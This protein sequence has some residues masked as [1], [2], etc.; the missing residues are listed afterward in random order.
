MR[1]YLRQLKLIKGNLGICGEKISDAKHIAAILNGLPSEFDSMVTLITSSRQAYDVPALSLMLID[2]EAR[3][4]SGAMARLFTVNLVTS[5]SNSHGAQGYQQPT[6]GVSDSVGYQGRRGAFV[7]TN[8]S[9]ASVN[10]A[11]V[12]K[13]VRFLDSRATSHLTRDAFS[14]TNSVPYTGAGKIINFFND[15]YFIQT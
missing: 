8:G 4:K 2:H 6:E 1:D 11:I 15:V 9:S 10:A 14:V 7:S 12:G 3:Q 13:H 5:Q